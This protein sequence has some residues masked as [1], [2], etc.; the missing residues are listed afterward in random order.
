MTWQVV[1]IMVSV[2]A[3]GVGVGLLLWRSDIR[4]GALDEVEAIT[5]RK[6]LDDIN[7]TMA[8]ERKAREQYAGIRDATPNDWNVI[9]LRA[10]DRLSRNPKAPTD[11]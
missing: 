2:A 5:N 6:A 9:K 10:Q 7:K 1:A 3:I 4:G 11:M 8:K